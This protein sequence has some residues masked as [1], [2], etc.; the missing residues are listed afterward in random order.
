MLQQER[1]KQVNI[2]NLFNYT[3]YYI[4]Q[5]KMMYSVR[6]TN[7]R[8]CILKLFCRTVHVHVHINNS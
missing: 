5:Y 4:Y 8:G 1:Q 3:I 7:L 6:L 2:C